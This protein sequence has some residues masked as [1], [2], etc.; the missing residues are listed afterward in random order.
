MWGRF[1]GE[2]S[3]YQ[4]LWAKGRKQD[5]AGREVGGSGAGMD[6]QRSCG[7][8]ARSLY[9]YPSIPQFYM[10][11]ALGTCDLGVCPLN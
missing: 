10:Q 3:W 5:G 1:I 4:H 9:K 11:I 2:C 7:K 6:L 8:G